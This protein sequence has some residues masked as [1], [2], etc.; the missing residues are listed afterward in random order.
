VIACRLAI[1]I[2]SSCGGRRGRCCA[3][4]G[5][6]IVVGGKRPSP[7]ARPDQDASEA[8]SSS[9]VVSSTTAGVGRGRA[10]GFG[11]TSETAGLWLRSGDCL[12]RLPEAIQDTQDF[13]F[14]VSSSDS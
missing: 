7:P 3:K 2:V 5:R 13:L 14:C 8:S 10:W 11:K 1:A 12:R 6:R 4:V 9:E